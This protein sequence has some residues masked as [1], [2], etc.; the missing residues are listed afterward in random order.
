MMYWKAFFSDGTEVLGL[1]LPS[2]LQC[3]VSNNAMI[4]CEEVT[5]LWWVEM[6]ILL[7][8]LLLFFI[9]QVVKRPGVKNWVKKLKSNRWSGYMSGSSG[10]AKKLSPKRT[11]LNLC[12]I[13]LSRWK[14]NWVSRASPDRCEILWSTSLIKEIAEAFCWPWDSIIIIIMG[15]MSTPV[16]FLTL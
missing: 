13:T 11:A 6:C 4:M 7:L 2:A 15:A 12:N 14:R 5:N 9:L 3:H 1:G 8:L 16:P 10:A